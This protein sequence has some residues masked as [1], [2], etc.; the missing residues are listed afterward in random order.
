MKKSIRRIAA[1]LLCACLICSNAYAYTFTELNNEE[2]FSQDI[3]EKENMSSWAKEDILAAQKAGLI[4]AMTGNPSYKDKITREQFAELVVQTVAVITEQELG[5]AADGTFTDTSNE[6][7]LI[8]YNLGI[9]DGIGNEKFAPTNTT[10]REQ[11]ATM[12][13]RAISSVD[14]LTGVNL[15][16]VQG[17]ISKF[18]DKDKVSSWAKAEVGTLAA[19]GIMEGTSATTLDPK[20][21]CTVEQSILLLYRVYSNY[22]EAK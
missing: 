10:N 21:S 5:A 3:I 18:S 7:I 11:I 16:P 20:S 4:P 6:K 19:N 12:V 22:M 13:A 8:A 17:D 2:I 15:A 1:G 14:G 9:V